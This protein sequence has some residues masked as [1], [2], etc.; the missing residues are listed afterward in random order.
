M[1][2]NPEFLR[3]FWLEMTMHRRLMMPVVLL[4]I[5]FITHSI[6]EWALVHNVSLLIYVVLTMLWGARLTGE[7]LI[8]E[9]DNRTWDQQR[10]SAIMPWQ[11]SWGK[12]FGSTVYVWYGALFTLPFF[13][14]SG[15]ITSVP[16][17]WLKLLDR[18]SVV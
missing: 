1:N 3:N 6:G 7:T 5:F 4:F 14:L 16:M 18:K 13:L 10:M 8:D 15:V 17:L 12:L 2:M 11:M 9:I